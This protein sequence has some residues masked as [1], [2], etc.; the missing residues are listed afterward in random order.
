MIDTGILANANDPIYF[1][2]HIRLLQ[3]VA[4]FD[5]TP[6]DEIGAQ[7]QAR[8]L[9]PRD[10]RWVIMTHLHQ[11]H[12]GGMVCFPNAEFLISRQEWAAAQGF[13]GRMNGY[14]PWHW[15][16]GLQPRLIDYQSGAYHSFAASEIVADGVRILPTPG[17]SRGHQSVIVEQGDHLLLFAGDVAYAQELLVGDVID[18]VGPD[19]AAE[20][21]S[22][23]RIMT[24]AAQI[25]TVFMPS[26][27][28]DSEMRL[29]QLTAIPT[30]D[31]VFPNR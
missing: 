6:A 23:R 20:H 24:L 10:V 17:H 13:A 8:G 1:P 15:P 11:D 26:H 12:D 4:P 30:S 9:D 18:G 27:D 31:F 2:P 3:R 21:N 5:I 29:R 7:M 28:P 22:H 19:P 14:L 25:P 16:Q